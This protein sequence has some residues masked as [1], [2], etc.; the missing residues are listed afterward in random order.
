MINAVSACCDNPRS[1]QHQSLATEILEW[2]M[3]LLITSKVR[4]IK[5]IKKLLATKFIKKW[6]C[7]VNTATVRIRNATGNFIVLLALKIFAWLT[8][9]AHLVGNFRF[10][11]LT[12]KWLKK[13]FDCF[14][15]FCNG[16]NLSE[17][18]TRNFASN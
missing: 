18:V 11:L 1:F 16:V 2:L 13:M 5:F 14:F 17:T 9:N 6:K 3:W 8:T 7:L 12:I 10:V 15:K 4:K